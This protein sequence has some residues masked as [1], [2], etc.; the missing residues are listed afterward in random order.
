MNKKFD[1][2]RKFFKK[3]LGSFGLLTL[4]ALLNARPGAASDKRKIVVIGGHPDDPECGAGGTI[5]LLVKAGHEVTLMYF[6]N[7]D[8]GIAG[9]DHEEAAAIRKK[10]A[11]EACKVL[12]AKPLFFNQTD[13]ESIVTNPE[14]ARFQK[15][16]WA[17]K[18]DMVLT[19]WPIDSHKDH[20]LASV[21]TMQ[22]WM[23]APESF[24]L[25]FYEVCIGY[26]SFIFHPTD[27]V[28]IT[29]TQ[30]LKWKALACHASQNI[31]GE[32]GKYTQVMRDCGQAAMED[33]RGRELGVHAAEAFVRMTGRG[34]GNLLLNKIK[35]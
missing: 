6:T 20:Q 9:K 35:E 15:M 17:E 28:D 7:G 10:E 23:E 29:E 13:G 22:S 1:S 8:E 5:P 33:F 24:S 19:H 12:G 25:Y 30:R 32:D 3:A 4:P 16:L 14:M 21:L 34:M 18:P 11:I 31:I 26:Q 27:Y 2:R